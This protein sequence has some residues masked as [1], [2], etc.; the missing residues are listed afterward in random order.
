MKRNVLF[1]WSVIV[2]LA[3]T[4]GANA[5]HK[6]FD[7]KI[8]E[9]IKITFN[10]PIQ[11]LNNQKISYQNVYDLVTLRAN[12]L[13]G[14]NVA[15]EAIISEDKTTIQIDPVN[16]L[17]YASTYFVTM[18]SV[19]DHAGN[20]TEPFNA[21]VFTENV[22]SVTEN[23][24]SENSDNKE[25]SIR[26]FSSMTNNINVYPNPVVD[27]L[28]IDNVSDTKTIAIHGI[29]GQLVKQIEPKNQKNIDFNLSHLTKGTYIISFYGN[30]GSVFSTNIIKL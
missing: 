4:L 26:D 15:F 21:M 17:E 14:E 12:N 1:L 27:M 10:E 24:V 6:V 30:Y 16:D 22:N 8:D 19:E 5:Q 3:V 28:H 18:A 11:T 7:K 29:N 20:A 23:N 2:F 13:N 9:N 25:F